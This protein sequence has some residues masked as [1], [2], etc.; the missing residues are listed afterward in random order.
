VAVLVAVSFEELGELL[1]DLGLGELAIPRYFYAV[2][3]HYFSFRNRSL[4]FMS[5]LVFHRY[6]HAAGAAGRAFQTSV[7][8]TSGTVAL[9]DAAVAFAVL[10]I[11]EGVEDGEDRLARLGRLLERAGDAE[12]GVEEVPH[13][14]G[15]DQGVMV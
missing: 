15:L 13:H 2:R 7:A 8:I 9:V 12:Q 14:G 3:S 5:L 11:G 4:R 6:E 1:S 10:G